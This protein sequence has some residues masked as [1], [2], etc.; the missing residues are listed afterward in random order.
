MRRKCNINPGRIRLFNRMDN[1]DQG[2]ERF[3]DPRSILP[4]PITEWSMFEEKELWEE[5][6]AFEKR[7]RRRV[8]KEN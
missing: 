1:I 6:A 3:D 5:N 2:W 4:R 7:M 8:T